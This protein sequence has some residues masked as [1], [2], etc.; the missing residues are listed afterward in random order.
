MRAALLK[1]STSMAE[2]FSFFHQIYIIRSSAITSLEMY[3]NQRILEKF[4]FTI[5]LQK[6]L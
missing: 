1:K 3:E 2:M 4:A 5:L 6:M